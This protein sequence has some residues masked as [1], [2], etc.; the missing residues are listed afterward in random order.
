MLQNNQAA[1]QYLSHAVIFK[2]N[3]VLQIQTVTMIQFF[4]VVWAHSPADFDYKVWP[5]FQHHSHIPPGQ[6]VNTLA[7]SESFG[8]TKATPV[9]N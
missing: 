9:H 8:I 7:S 1:S 4:I 2:M 5:F 3:Y 6:P